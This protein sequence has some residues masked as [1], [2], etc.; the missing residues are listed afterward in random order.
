MAGKLNMNV[1]FVG[2]VDHGKSTSVGRLLYDSGVVPEQE[3]KKLKDEA[4]KH[5]KVGFEFA[6]VMDHLKEERERGVT[7]DL[8]YRKLMTKKYQITII[9]APGHKDF[10]KNM[11]TGA[12]QADCAI[13]VLS[14]KDGVQP[15]TQEHVFLCRTMGVGQMAVLINKMD[16]VE[17]DE[18]KYLQVKEDIIKLLKSAGYNTEKINFIAASAYLGDNI[19]KKSDKMKWYNGPT[20]L[21]QFDLFEEPKK[22]TELPLR[23]PLQEVYTITGIGTV[24]VG[25]IETGRMKP[26]D[27]VI[28]LPAR[29]GKGIAGE[30]K[31][32]EMHHENLTEAIAGDNVGVNIRGVGKQDIARG[33]VI[34]A[35]DKPATIAAEF[36]AQIA[37]IAH[38]TV[39]AKGYTPVFHIHTAQVPCQFIEL[40]KKIDP[41]TGQVSQEN[42]DFLKNGDV[43]IVK[44]KPLRPLVIEKQS[45]NP[46]MARFAIRDA[47]A[48]VAAGICIDLVEKKLV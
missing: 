10:V 37:V 41:K 1:V 21:E 27:K 38:P 32:I 48:T 2:H 11:I 17:F 36:T 29:E 18:K 47:G 23:M 12:S 13:L 43:A 24:P 44:I 45:V 40:Q 7:I 5:G 34:C 30:I 25:K 9:D 42:P 6:F 20:L 19:A 15:Q 22:Q 39:I 8:S 31:S 33:D 14:A 3:L 4:A 16:T 28:I 46:H 35:A 26:G